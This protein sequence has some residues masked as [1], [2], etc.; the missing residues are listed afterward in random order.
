MACRQIHYRDE[1]QHQTVCFYLLGEQA[2][3]L[4]PVPGEDLVV[5]LPPAGVDSDVARQVTDRSHHH[6]ARD[7]QWKLKSCRSE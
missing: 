5:E 4:T 6:Q 7:V 2:V 1:L 3:S